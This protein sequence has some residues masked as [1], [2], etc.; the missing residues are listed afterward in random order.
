MKFI[1]KIKYWQVTT[2][3][4]K[5]MCR[6]KTL[7]W[8]I[9]IVLHRFCVT[10]PVARAAWPRVRTIRYNIYVA[11]VAPLPSC[12]QLKLAHCFTSLAQIAAELSCEDWT[13]DTAGQPPR[14][15]QHYLCVIKI[16]DA[17]YEFQPDGSFNIKLSTYKIYLYF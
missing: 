6:S 15:A 3:S 10:F 12:E 8:L 16:I 5:E 2:D 14:A 9:N 4:A 1:Y 11:D 7:Y 13:V 17:K